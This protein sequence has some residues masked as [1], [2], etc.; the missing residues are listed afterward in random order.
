[1]LK[2]PHAGSPSARPSPA[3]ASAVT[4]ATAA[5]AFPSR[6]RG[7][8]PSGA[9][10]SGR[11][12]LAELAGG[13]PDDAPAAQTLR[14]PPAT[15]WSPGR[16]VCE[17]R[18]G[19][20]ITL[21]PGVVFGGWIACLS[22]HFAGLVMLSALPDGYGFLTAGLSTGYHAPLVPGEVRIET[23]L[24]TCTTR[25]AV[26]EVRFEQDGRLA[27]RS[28]VEQIIHRR[29]PMAAPR[30]GEARTSDARQ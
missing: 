18:L 30:T 19:D 20:E 7:I 17:T 28:V 14:L 15:S 13:T 5:P 24:T 9:T 26:A 8:A 12:L 23:E 2:T 16:V 4:A 25:L 6:L 11:A 22:D 27:S 21:T 3:G 10:T 29:D 1:M